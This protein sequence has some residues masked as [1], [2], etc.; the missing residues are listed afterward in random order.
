MK[1]TALATA[2]AVCVGGG[3]AAPVWAQASGAA[4][5]TQTVIVTSQKR[6]ED[7]KQ[8][9]L[10]I[11]V[12]GGDAMKDGQIVNFSDLA[13]SV[14]NLSF[15]SQ[16][17]AGLSTLQL[18]GISSQAGSATVAIY[19]DDISLTT[20][21]LYSQ[22]TTEPK[23]FDIERLE[24]L[25]GPQGTLYGGSA[26]GGTLKFISKQPNL[27]SLEGGASAEISSTKSGG[28]NGM[29]QGVLNIPLSKDVMA[30][31]IGVQSGKESGYIDQVDVNS[32]K[33][34]EK[35][36]NEARWDVVKL[37]LKA[38]INKDWSVTPALFYQRYKSD[39]IDAAYRAVGDYQSANAGVVLPQFQTSK[40]V[41]EPGSD[42]L[43]VPSVTVAGDLGFA[44]VTGIVSGYKRRFDRRQDG[45]YI[46]SVYIGEVTT[47]RDLGNNIIQ[48]L[49]SAV[50]LNNRVKQT[51]VELR[52]A[53]KDY[54]AGGSPFTWLGGLYSERL[55]TE[56]FDN[57]PVFGITEAFRTAGYDINNPAHLLDTFSGAFAGDS[58]YYSARHYN[59]RQ[60][61]VFGQ[62]TYHASPSLRATV[63]LRAL[64]AKQHFTREGDFYYAGGPTTAVFDFSESATT[65]RLAISWD[66]SKEVSH[67]ANATKG[68]RLGSANRPVPL[69]EIVKRD[70]AEMGLPQ[71]I[72][73]SYQSD[74]LWNYE[75]GSKMRL[76]NGLSLNVALYY[77]KWKDIQQN[78][79][80]PNAGFDFE[81]NVGKA[82]SYGFEVD[83]RWRVTSDLTINASGSTTHA[84]FSEDMPALGS[85]DDGLNV[86]KGDRIQGV[87]K[88]NA[89]LG[90]E[91]RFP[92]MGNS[93]FVR[94]SA[95]WVGSSK[96]SFV[97]SDPDFVRPGYMTADASV[98]VTFDK[99]EVIAFVKNLTNN[100]KVI[101][102]PNIQGVDTVYHL[103]PRTIGVT[104]NYEF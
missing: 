37:G 51:A 7:V 12:L 65:P 58:S 62:L 72:P 14:P 16:A 83:A 57:E 63:G 20:R 80:L 66:M 75:V 96:G 6:K 88:Y 38:Q 13:R 18:R 30:L 84:T 98:G 5:D 64:R 81:T 59:D 71:T 78:V 39:D 1:K 9:P 10:A 17:G 22:G 70:L 49:P 42:T 29:L 79:R 2:V 87:P 36:I 35:N 41:R 40:I 33:V 97:R 85:S 60:S 43:T 103:R 73:G 104:A 24:V 90:F 100:D 4:T 23:F 31:R 28:L 26:M 3:M 76:A 82:A 54:E 47:D 19:L 56:V 77:I 21:N 91:Y 86:R 55:K 44:D 27:R 68:F 99:L 45:T 102:Q 95:D 69:T 15:S 52:L 74:E 48:Y 25:Y 11:T 34:I 53:S 8:V 92:A 32:L 67:Y 50:D 61:A 46:N 101:Q 89:K 93:A 94:A